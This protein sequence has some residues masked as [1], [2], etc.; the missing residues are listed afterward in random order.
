M[1]WNNNETLVSVSAVGHGVSHLVSAAALLV[2]KKI[3]KNMP[4]PLIFAHPTLDEALESA[5]VAPKEN[6]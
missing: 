5:M 1:L 4:L 6:I 3:Q 2:G